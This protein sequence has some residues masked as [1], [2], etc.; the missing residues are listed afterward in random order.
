MEISASLNT[1]R[2]LHMTAAQLDER[3][4]QGVAE[5]IPDGESYGTMI[6]RLGTGTR[7]ARFMAVILRVGLWQGKIFYPEQGILYNKVSPLRIKAE[8]ARVYQEASWLD[9]RESIIVDYATTASFASRW[10]R[11]EIRMVA[12]GLYLG[13]AY[14]RKTRQPLVYFL[15][16]FPR[17]RDVSCPESA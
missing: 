12:P 8:K 7:Y 3:F 16:E 1:T 9:G 5:P 13:I 14:R 10:I 2:L 15:L 4:R 11:D 6:V 17:T